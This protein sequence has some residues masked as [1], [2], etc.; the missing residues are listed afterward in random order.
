MSR[1]VS[2]VSFRVEI[3]S[4]F[5]ELVLN[6]P[7]ID[8]ALIDR[9]VQHEA[10]KG[11]YSH[12]F[13]F[14]NT[15][16]TIEDFWLE[17][18]NK[19]TRDGY[20]ENV[21]RCLE[22]VNDHLSDFTDAFHELE[23]YIPPGID[24]PT[25]LFLTV[26]YDI[27]IVSEGCAYLNLGHSLFHMNKRELLYFA[28]HELHHVAYTHYQ[29]I[30][31]FD[32]VKTR[33][34]LH[35]VIKY[36]THLEG[37][38]VYA[39]YDRRRRENGFSHSDYLSLNDEEKTHRLVKNYF[40]T[41]N[42]AASEPD[43]ALAAEDWAILDLMSGEDRLWYVVGAYMAETIDRHLGRASLVSTI[44]KGYDSFFETYGAALNQK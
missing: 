2:P 29:P 6:L 44:E 16:K 9:V 18:L 3:D 38:A 26:G 37:L 14:H 36:S 10:A 27:G 22:Y 17:R 1:W 4:S 7:I 40:D 43:K 20:Y 12:A 13:R 33:G 28:M 8:D 31:S 32:D 5:V 15:D 11:I 42:A 24:L 35:K 34:D 25:T 30:Y 21:Q 41:L 23:A 19:S 39:P